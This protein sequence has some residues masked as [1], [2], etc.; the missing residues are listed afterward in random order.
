[1]RSIVYTN[2]ELADILNKNRQYSVNVLG[3]NSN[4]K[5]IQLPSPDSALNVE[6]VE[7]YFYWAEQEHEDGLEDNAWRYISRW[8]EKHQ[9]VFQVTQEGDLIDVSV[10]NTPLEA[11]SGNSILYV[12]QEEALHHC[13]VHLEFVSQY[14]SEIKDSF[15]KC[16][17][18]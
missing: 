13:S 14:I 15:V 17:R 2:A 11:Y 4:S 7:D 1:M 3:S 12:N 5:I 10:I 6:L 9:E 16:V 8:V 18:R